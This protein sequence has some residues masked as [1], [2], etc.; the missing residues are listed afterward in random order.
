MAA[1]L[2]HLDFKPHVGKVFR[3]SGSHVGLRLIK[4]DVLQA[5]PGIDHIP[6]SAI[7]QGPPGD[8]L[9]EGL[10]RASVEGGGELEFYISPVHTPQRD[11]QDY[12]AVF[13]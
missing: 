6:F 12:Q 13:N 10:Y 8:I 2:T 7:F 9:P 1:L 5:Y 4:V 3:F 11:R